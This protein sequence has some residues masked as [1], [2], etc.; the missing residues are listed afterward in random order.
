MNEKQYTQIREDL[1]N[2]PDLMIPCENGDYIETYQNTK[3]YEVI[4]TDDELEN[5]EFN[6]LIINNG[7]FVKVMSIDFE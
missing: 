2:I 6:M 1:R 7:I 3:L 5:D 4:D